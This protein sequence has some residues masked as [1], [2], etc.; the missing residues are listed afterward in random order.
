MYC[1]MQAMFGKRGRDSYD[2]DDDDSTGDMEAS[3]DEIMQEEQR[4]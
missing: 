3:Y 2:Y 4:R 1:V